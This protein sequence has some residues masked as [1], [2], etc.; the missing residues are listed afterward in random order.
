MTSCAL[1]NVTMPAQISSWPQ[2][3]R[4][5]NWVATGA[6]DNLIAQG[7][8]YKQKNTRPWQQAT[9]YWCRLDAILEDFPLVPLMGKVASTRACEWSCSLVEISRDLWSGYLVW[10]IQL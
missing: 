9:R 5:K 3:P 7:R 8:Y 2:G 6:L 4:S 1:P 10:I